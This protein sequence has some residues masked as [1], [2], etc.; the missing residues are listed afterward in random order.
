[1]VTLIEW[2]RKRN[3]KWAN[4]NEEKIGLLFKGNLKG[5]KGL[6][7]KKGRVGGHRCWEITYL[8]RITQCLV[9]KQVPS[10]VGGH[11]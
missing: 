8:G 6:G 4:I 5:R 7:F 9:K 2:A 1:M 11:A 3:R 10:G